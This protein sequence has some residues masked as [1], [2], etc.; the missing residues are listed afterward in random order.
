VKKTKGSNQGNNRSTWK[1][2]WRNM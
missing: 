2:I 1:G